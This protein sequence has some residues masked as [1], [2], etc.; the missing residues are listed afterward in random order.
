MP[1]KSRVRARLRRLEDRL[2][3]WYVIS[4]RGW[5]ALLTREENLLIVA[6]GALAVPAWLAW[7]L[8]YVVLANVGLRALLFVYDHPLRVTALLVRLLELIPQAYLEAVRLWAAAL[9]LVGDTLAARVVPGWQNVE[10]LVSSLEGLVLELLRL[11]GRLAT[12]ALVLV[13]RETRFVGRRLLHLEGWTDLLRALQSF[14]AP[15]VHLIQEAWDRTW[16]A[17][18]VGFLFEVDD[19]FRRC[20]R[21]VGLL[22]LLQGLGDDV[23][24]T[25]H[26]WCERHPALATAVCAALL[27]VAVAAPLV[28]VGAQLLL[29]LRR[30][31][32]VRPARARLGLLLALLLGGAVSLGGGYLVQARLLRFPPGVSLVRVGFLVWPLRRTLF[33]M[34]CRTTY[35][36]AAGLL[37]AIAVATGLLT[38]P[39]LRYVGRT[40]LGYLRDALLPCFGRL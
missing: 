17:A 12:R 8:L 40:T 34:L 13:E 4:M 21:G 36:V 9:F 32:G 22:E 27:L 24:A 19:G 39:V 2:L 5:T 38:W 14:A 31:K 35:S 1:R 3:S 29:R 16:V 37:V 26:V 6:G 33:E 20:M 28:L 18:R 23:R 10:P 7:Q 15:V 11:V 25:T 30:R